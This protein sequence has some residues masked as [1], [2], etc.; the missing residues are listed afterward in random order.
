MWYPSS[1][2]HKDKTAPPSP[3]S[4]LLSA[5][6]ADVSSKA[7]HEASQTPVPPASRLNRADESFR[8]TGQH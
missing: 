3:T 6:L 4:T 1:V 2:D 5:R 8:A 7:A